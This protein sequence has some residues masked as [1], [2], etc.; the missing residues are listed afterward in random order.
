MMFCWRVVDV[1]AFSSSIL[2]TAPENLL[3]G[4][5]LMM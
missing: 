3:D 2:A 5:V 1:G 4:A